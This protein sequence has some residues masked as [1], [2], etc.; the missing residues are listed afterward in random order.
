MT[1]TIISRYGLARCP[2]CSVHNKV[3]EIFENQQCCTFCGAPI[4]LQTAKEVDL[5]KSS[6]SWMGKKGALLAASLLGLAALS[7]ACEP[8]AAAVYGIPAEYTAA[9]TP[10]ETPVSDAGSVDK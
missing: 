9:E 7:S 5:S 2:S 4:Q 8:P 3:E 1:D 10:G 6:G